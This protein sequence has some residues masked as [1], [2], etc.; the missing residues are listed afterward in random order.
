MALERLLYDAVPTRDTLPTTDPIS[1][2]KLDLKTVVLAS[3]GTYYDRDTIRQW[4]D[5]GHRTSPMTREV[6]RPWVLQAEPRI[7]THLMSLRV[8]LWSAEPPLPCI[9]ALWNPPSPENDCGS[10]D[11]IHIH[12][13]AKAS[14]WNSE[15]GVALRSLLGWHD[16]CT[17]EWKY[18][19]LRNERTLALPRPVDEFKVIGTVLAQWIGLDLS[20]TTNPSHAVCAWFRC[21][22]INEAWDTMESLILGS[23]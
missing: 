4:C 15:Q 19:L 23:S 9:Q 10:E 14:Q 5:Q 6:L 1:H 2:E 12:G 8:D 3:D 22:N 20:Q 18:P 16:E 21:P 13:K 17:I 11:W 7:T